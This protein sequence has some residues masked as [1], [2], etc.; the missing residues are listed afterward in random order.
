MQFI[1]EQCTI[2]IDVIDHGHT[3]RMT[4][5]SCYMWKRTECVSFIIQILFVKTTLKWPA[6]TKGLSLSFIWMSGPVTKNCIFHLFFI[7]LPWGMKTNFKTS[8]K[9]YENCSPALNIRHFFFFII[10]EKSILFL[11]ILYKNKSSV[12]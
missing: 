7:S 4:V 10:I 2:R 5:G 6:R 12:V 11:L 8:S 3:M 9:R 1:K